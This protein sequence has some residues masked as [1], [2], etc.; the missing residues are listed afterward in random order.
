L[1]KNAAIDLALD[2]LQIALGADLKASEVEVAVL[3]YEDGWK[4][5]DEQT[6]DDILVKLSDKD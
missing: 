3:T 4:V 5:L 6:V 1:D 2:V